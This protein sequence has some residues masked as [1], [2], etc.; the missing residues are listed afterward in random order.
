MRVVFLGTPE[1]A[2]PALQKL[3]ENSYEICSVFTQPDRPAGRGQKLQPC[4][5]KL[6]AQAEGIPVFQPEKIQME[7]NRVLFESIHPDFIVVV[8]YGQ[9]LPGWLLE[10]ARIAPIN[11][12]ASLL[13]RYRGA[14]PIAWAI[15]NGEKTTG[16]TTMI[17]QE[18]LDS[19]PILMRQEIP[20]V[21]SATEGELSTELSEIGANLLIQTLD[22]LNKNAVNP[23]V[24]NE[25]LVTWA[26][27][28][29]KAMAQISWERTAFELHNQIRG[30]NP[31]PG[32]YCSFR[33]GRLHIW[34]SM[35][36]EANASSVP[37]ALIGVS[38][39]GIRIQ[40]GRGTVLD[41]LEVQ[42]PGK[43]RITGKQLASGAHLLS[44]D[45]LF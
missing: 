16:V 23:V 36:G 30:L 1:F 9:I 6:R 42:M 4:P 13:P 45:I 41:L 28:L 22:E 35:P 25:S 24:Q 33:S 17:M 34:R 8:A 37:G 7:D 18:K 14:A 12:H 10:S 26:P 19:G 5:V 2:V 29:T 39:D 21:F 11:I 44:G 43:S 38:G 27:R 31:S 3:I 40:C 20:I 15:M 32:A